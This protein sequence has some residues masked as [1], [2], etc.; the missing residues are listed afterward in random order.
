MAPAKLGL[1]LKKRFLKANFLVCLEKTTFFRSKTSPL[2]G[3]VCLTPKGLSKTKPLV[4]IYP[5]EAGQM[6]V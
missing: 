3:L 1:P 6:F 2:R 5:A 4:L